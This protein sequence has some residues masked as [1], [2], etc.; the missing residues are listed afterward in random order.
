M[1]P[2]PSLLVLFLASCLAA[3]P[4][5]EAHAT[6]DLGLRF[7][8]PAFVEASVPFTQRLA[9]RNFANDP[10]SGIVVTIASDNASI[11]GASA[12]GWNCNASGRQATCSA[13]SLGPGESVLT[14]RF[15][16]APAFGTTRTDARV[17]TLGTFDAY[18]ANDSASWTSRVYA[19]SACS[20][21][22][23]TILA[24]A[25]AAN[26]DSP[27]RFAWTPGPEASRYRV[28]AAV[29]G[30][31]AILLVET[32]DLSYT[33]PIE[34]GAIEWWV[35]SIVDGCPPVA[36]FHG[37]FQSTQPN[38]ALAVTT[39]R[40][41]TPNST[42]PFPWIEPYSLAL[43]PDGSL[44]VVDRGASTI[45]RTA[46]DGTAEAVAGASGVTGS[47]DGVGGDARFNHPSGI[48]IDIN[49]S[50]YIAD[51]GNDTLRDLL[52]PFGNRPTYNV[53][54]IAGVIGSPGGEDGAPARLNNP[55][56]VFVDTSFNLFFADTGN[57]CLRFFLIGPQVTTMAGSAGAVGSSDGTRLMARF[58]GPEGLTIA[59]NGDFYIAD[60]G[61][62][63]IRRMTRDGVVTT[64][65]GGSGLAALQD[66]VGLQAR[67]NRPT[68]LAFDALGNLYICDTG[69]HAIRKLAPS[70]RV[71]TVA[72]GKQGS[73]D[74][75]GS[76][77]QFNAPTGI[78][79]DAAGR[80][81]IA[82]SG[83]GSIRT[84]APATLRRLRA[85]KH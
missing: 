49:G 29:E 81:Y 69:N 78:V 74:G 16:A 22:A 62:H 60:S 28:W 36:S 35:E 75:I 9:V 56:A 15:G 80:I 84:A 68:G 82:D 8:T 48:A 67:F 24:P 41:H 17:Q 5:A 18:G 33:A 25:P 58:D 39:L 64:V 46:M 53:G 31:K 6:V 20:A 2:K 26:I 66:G 52:P 40:T 59:P 71:T 30:A 57:D 45:V 51:S 4:R 7:D 79:I 14:V 54:R 3:V 85:V 37:E 50:V 61:N 65:A 27:V 10:A 34:M 11:S 43:A 13:E 77:A 63:L 1:K 55:T 70:G 47:S 19:A 73:R 12:S 38:A 23:P 21:A 72:G 83:N 44:W 42:D 32:S 76:S